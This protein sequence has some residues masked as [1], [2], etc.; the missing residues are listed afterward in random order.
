MELLAAIE[1]TGIEGISKVTRKERRKNPLSRIGP[2]ASYSHNV[3]YPAQQHWIQ[4]I[5]SDSECVVKAA[6]DSEWIPTWKACLFY[7]SFK[8]YMCKV[9]ADSLAKRAVRNAVVVVQESAPLHSRTVI[10]GL[11]Q[12]AANALVSVPHTGSNILQLLKHEIERQLC[13]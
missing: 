7:C 2:A 1:G 5:T 9:V 10:D 3:R 12:C 6:T 4:V 8:S 13:R 11:V